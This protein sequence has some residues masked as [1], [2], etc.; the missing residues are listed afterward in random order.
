MLGSSSGKTGVA[1]GN[2]NVLEM[3]N[4]LDVSSLK[5]LIPELG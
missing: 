1:E 4:H 5:Q 2:S 3:R